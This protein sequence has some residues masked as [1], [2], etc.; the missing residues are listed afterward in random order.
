VTASRCDLAVSAVQYDAAFVGELFAAIGPRLITTPVWQGHASNGAS[1]G[2]VRLGLAASSVFDESDSTLVSDRS[3]L[4]L[5]VHQRLWRHHE[6]TRTHAPLLR[7]RVRDDPASVVVLTLDDEPLPDWLEPVRRCGLAAA[8]LGGAVDFALDAIASSGGAVNGAPTPAARSEP[9]Q[10]WM[11]PPAPF[12]G[13]PR[14]HSA[15]RHELDALSAQL[16]ASL[17]LE[18]ARVP[19]RTGEL[20]S[21]PHRLIARLGETGVSF[22]WVAGVGSAV[23]DG[24]LLVIEWRDVVKQAR[25]A[26]VL[27][28]ATPVLERTYRPEGTNADSWRWRVD[29][30][31]G[32][33]FSSQHLAAAWVAGLSIA[34]AA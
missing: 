11:D 24:R 33:A 25:G 1:D 10:G 23:A 19:E 18:Q 26:A 28:A 21:L 22:S 17:A 6:S 8:G 7:E 13:Q 34:A 32:V 27:R 3:R 16:V 20:I 2:V 29:E 30:P 5:V 9:A 4:A 14:A 15:L 12:L 31:N